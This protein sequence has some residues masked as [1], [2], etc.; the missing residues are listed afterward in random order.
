MCVW[1]LESRKKK[2]KRGKKE[3]ERREEMEKKALQNKG[4]V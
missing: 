1:P 2:I 3:K 4:T